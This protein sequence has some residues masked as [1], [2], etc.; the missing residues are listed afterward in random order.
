[1]C[2]K[3]K[4]EEW[5]AKKCLFGECNECGVKNVVV[6]L[7]KSSGVDP[8]IVEWRWFAMEITLSRAGHPL[9]KPT[10]VYKRTTSNE[11]LDYLKPKLQVF[12][13]HNFNVQWQDKHFKMCI[14]S[15]PIGTVV[16]LLILFR[17]TILRCKMRFNA[18]IN[19]HSRLIFLCILPL[20]TILMQILMMRTFT[21]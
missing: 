13:R 7:V 2:A 15:F 3:S 14:K 6:C 18:C 17:T 10:L 21:F 8:R 16:Q 5:H 4:I 9:K 12:V 20:G 19:K 11:M 1:M